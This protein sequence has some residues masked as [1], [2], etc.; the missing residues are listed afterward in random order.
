MKGIYKEFHLSKKFKNPQ[1]NSKM[2]KA[3]IAFKENYQASGMAQRQTL[4]PT[5]GIH[6]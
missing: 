6:P 4:R 5:G 3:A 1:N 2:Q